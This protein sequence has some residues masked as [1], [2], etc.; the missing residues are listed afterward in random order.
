MWTLGGGGHNRRQTQ[1]TKKQRGGRRQQAEGRGGLGR[2]AAPA[3]GDKHQRTARNRADARK[4]GASKGT[5]AAERQHPRN[6]N[7][8]WRTARAREA[9]PS[10]RAR[11]KGWRTR[12][13]WEADPSAA[14]RQTPQT[15]DTRERR[16]YSGGDNGKPTKQAEQRAGYD[17]TNRNPK[18][19]TR[20]ASPRGGPRTNT[21][22]PNKGGDRA[23]AQS[24]N[25]G[26]A[27]TTGNQ[28][29]TTPAVRRRRQKGTNKTSR[30]SSR[31][32][33]H[34]PKPEH[35]DK[36]PFTKGGTTHKHGTPQ[37]GGGHAPAQHQL[38]QAN[39]TTATATHPTDDDNRNETPPPQQAGTNT[40]RPTKR[41]GTH[42][43]S[44]P[45]HEGGHKP[46]QHAPPWGRHTATHHAP[47][48]RGAGTNTARP[49]K[50]G[51][52]APAEH[53]LRPGTHHRQPTPD[54]A[55]STASK[56]Q[57]TNKTSRASSR[58]QHHEPKPKHAD[59]ARPTK[60][61]ATHKHG[62]PQQGGEHA[63]TQHQ[64]RPSQQHN[65]NHNP[66]NRRRQPEPN[67]TNPNT[68][69]AA[70][71]HRHSMP[72]REGGHKPTQ[73]APPWGGGHTPTQHAPLWWGARTNTA[74]PK[75]GGGGGTH[76]HGGNPGQANNITA[77]ATV[78][79]RQPK[80]NTTTPRPTNAA[81]GHHHS[82]PH[83]E[84]DHKPT[85][86]APPWGGGTHQHSTPHHEGGRAPTENQPSP[87]DQHNHNHNPT[88]DHT[89]PN[90]P[91][92]RRRRQ[93]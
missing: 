59:T 32:Q 87:G 58:L 8:G 77:T 76:Q 15:T 20:H 18:K 26:Q 29:P 12:R 5:R 9:G 65:R 35:A 14:A 22:R 50:G 64:P 40:A 51:G 78:R 17:T 38:G 73:H 10:D 21:A 69:W 36:A 80:P 60:G 31:L 45:H 49:N 74:R 68:T 63:P 1:D 55:G 91:T 67:T 43:H 79:R 86:H 53:Q 82:T 75:K 54:N 19:P 13:A 33:H 24:T 6:K 93:H 7:M 83:Q 39:N 90:R 92:V 89:N 37:Q 71:R 70:G 72:H 23:P 48:W 88:A 66:H 28:H 56:R 34:K 42:R 84:G 41:G 62:T 44:M 3:R 2:G 27:N 30:A 11:T 57:R 4:R 16:P 47:P 61:W 46:A 52:G 85:Q 81:G 25:P